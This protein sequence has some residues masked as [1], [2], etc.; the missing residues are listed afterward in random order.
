M[1]GTTSSGLSKPW[2][3]SVTQSPDVRIR[4]IASRQYGVFTR[5]QALVAGL[6]S[7]GIYRRTRS[8]IFMRVHPGVFTLSGS[9]ASFESRVMALCLRAPGRTWACG[10]TAAILWQL[11]DFRPNLVE[12]CSIGFLE[13]APEALIHHVTEIPGRDVTTLRRIP[14]TNVHRTLADLGSVV[15]RDRVEIAVE[16]ALRRRLTSTHHL[17]RRVREL[18]A[19]GRVGSAVLRAILVQRGAAPPT[20]SNLETRF[21]QFLR[22]YRLP[23]P[24]RQKRVQEGDFLVRVDFYYERKA[25]IIEVDSRSHHLRQAQWERDLRRRNKLTSMGYKVL[26]VTHER[27]KSDPDGLYAEIWAVLG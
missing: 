5:A 18:E 8:G 4:R 17:W 27:L 9:A 24:T 12:V 6:S 19:R 23:K 15:S 22:R 3:L 25:V 7:G 2:N 14:V 10:Q 1:M 20:E 16:C 21:L 26:H 13:P 11:D